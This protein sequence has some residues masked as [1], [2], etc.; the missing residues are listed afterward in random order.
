MTS[1]LQQ[2]FSAAEML[3]PDEQD[4]LASRLLAELSAERA[5]DQA[6]AATS[7]KLTSLARE[8]MSEHVAGDTL[9]LDPD[10]L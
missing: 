6:I 8:A 9:E 1:L 4:L 2:A 10:K 7:E 5:F 3:P